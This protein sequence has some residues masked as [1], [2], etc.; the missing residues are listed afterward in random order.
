MFN[1]TDPSG[2][3]FLAQAG[4]LDEYQTI[5]DVWYQRMHALPDS[6]F[7][8]LEAFEEL[9]SLGASETTV[10]DWRAFPVTAPATPEEIDND[11]FRFQDE[12][13]EW[14]VERDT[15]G[16]L[17]RVTVTTEFPEYYE[18]L[19]RKGADALKAEIANIHPGANPTD[20]ELFGPG[21]DPNSA[22]PLSRADRLRRNLADN[23][24]NN[25]ERDI[26]CLTQQ[27]NTMGA[28][29]NLVGHCGVKRPGLDPGEVC[30]NV[31]GFCGPNRN[32]DPRVCSGAQNIARADRSLGLSDPCGIKILSLDPAALWTVDGQDVDIN[33]EAAN[34]GVWK[35]T[36][37]G[38][39]AVMLFNRDVRSGGGQF[40]TG[41]QLSNLLNVGAAVVHAANDDL[42]EWARTGHEE[43][44]GPIA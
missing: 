26:L 34:Q 2:S 18:A 10:I 16:A 33:D 12:Y 42:P 25:G 11:R 8:L 20:A 23:P 6:A 5:V 9:S 39:R 36:R 14:R 31:G 32:S 41:A 19:A 43:T 29:F 3:G 40:L 17:A 28:L 44:R 21:F 38:R 1:Y 35:V 7:T 13:V 15:A 37:N 24:W 30:A 22:S 27:F 4:A